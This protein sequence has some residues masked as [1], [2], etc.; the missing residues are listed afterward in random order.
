MPFF[1]VFSFVLPR[2]SVCAVYD[3]CSRLVSVIVEVFFRFTMSY[4]IVFDPVSGE[5]RLGVKVVFSMKI[6]F[7][8]SLVNDL[9]LRVAMSLVND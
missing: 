6:A 8:M 9:T 7:A 3:G 4:C 1:E 5:N 2:S